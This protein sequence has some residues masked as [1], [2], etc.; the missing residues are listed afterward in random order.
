MSTVAPW[1]CPNCMAPVNTPF[2]PTCGEHPV[3]SRDF[4][5]R[6][7]FAQH[8]K[9]I[10]GVDSR[11]VRSFRCLVNQPGALTAAYHQGRRKPFI[12]PFQ[13]FLIANV[14]FFTVQSMT[15]TPVF[16]SPLESHLHVQD[17]SSLAQRLVAQRLQTSGLTLERY[18]PLFDQ[19]VVL[20]AKS[21]VILMV[22]PFSLLLPVLFFRPRRAL[23]THV[24]FA[25]HLYAFLL[26]LYCLSLAISAVDVRLGGAG[27]ASPGMDN[28]LTAANLAVCGVYAYAAIGKVY[29]AKGPMRVAQALAIALVVSSLVVGYRFLI[30]LITLYST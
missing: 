27:L 18:A 2:C 15:S 22:L 9:A 13:L 29:E 11:L 6:G 17:W 8:W 30:F 16:S 5:L 3:S 19:A 25:L 20:N 10:T 28:V 4:T 1:T 24:V 23:A 26:L 21:L 14:V 7:L 12:G